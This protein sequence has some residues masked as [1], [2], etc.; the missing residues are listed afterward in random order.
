MPNYRYIAPFRMTRLWRVLLISLV[1]LI[2]MIGNAQQLSL[3]EA[4]KIGEHPT[5]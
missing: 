5:T 4:L 1:G 3:A 2:P